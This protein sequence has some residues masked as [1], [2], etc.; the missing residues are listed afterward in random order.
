MRGLMIVH[1]CMN[2]E[3]VHHCKMYNNMI[4]RKRRGFDLY[5]IEGLGGHHDLVA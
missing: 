2:R 3:V 5:S 1:Y 4:K